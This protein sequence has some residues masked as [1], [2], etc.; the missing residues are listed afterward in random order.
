MPAT[1]EPLHLLIADTALPPGA[2][3]GSLPELPPLP[4]LQALLARMRLQ[5][6][7]EVDEDSPATPFE[8]ALARAH[9][10]LDTLA[11]LPALHDPKDLFSLV[12]EARTG[13]ELT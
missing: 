2:P 10:L 11:L 9:G 12:R 4:H 3:A 8:Q 7:L 5:A 13:A 6:T 1:A